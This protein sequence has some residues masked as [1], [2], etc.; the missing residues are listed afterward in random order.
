MKTYVTAWE[1]RGKAIRASTVQQ[2]SYRWMLAALVEGRLSRPTW[3]RTRKDAEVVAHELE[4][5]HYVQGRAYQ[6]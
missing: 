5:K 4:L 1:R 3:Y 2:G 6:R